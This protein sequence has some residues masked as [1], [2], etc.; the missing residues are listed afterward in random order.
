MKPWAQQIVVPLAVAV[1]TRSGLWDLVY[2][3]ADKYNI[4]VVLESGK[5]LAFL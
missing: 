5:V 4:K 3:R 2:K 1:L